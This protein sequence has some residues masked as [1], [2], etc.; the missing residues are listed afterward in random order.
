M[1]SKIRFATL[2][3]CLLAFPLYFPSNVSYA[4]PKK[5]TKSAQKKSGLT[6]AQKAAASK[7][8][9]QLRALNSVVEIGTIYA[10]YSRR[11]VDTKIEIDDQLSSL[12]NG[13]L[14]KSILAAL[15]AHK[16]ARNLW[17][18]EEGDQGE[19]IMAQ[20]FHKNG[21]TLDYYWKTANLQT[22][23]AAQLMK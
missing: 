9:K 5:K 10:D 3:A 20:V 12:P 7:A 16:G 15:E 21:L 13:G 18:L 23:K 8:V 1:N 6:T 17:K 19:Q 22:I 2:F 4:A 14:K 11:V